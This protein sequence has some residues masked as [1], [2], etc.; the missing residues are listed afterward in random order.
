[1]KLEWDA[2]RWDA[3][4]WIGMPTRFTH[5]LI[6]PHFWLYEIHLIWL[7]SQSGPFLEL[8]IIENSNHIKF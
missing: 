8:S 6:F 2:M 4:E 3:M 1:M 7:F 5:H